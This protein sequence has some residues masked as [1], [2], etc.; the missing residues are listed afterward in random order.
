MPMTPEEADRRIALLNKMAATMHEAI[1]EGYPENVVAEVA[2]ENLCGFVVA[3]KTDLTA[4]IPSRFKEAGRR[5]M[6]L[7][8]QRALFLAEHV[9]SR[10]PRALQADS[11]PRDG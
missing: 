1:A 3:T 8:A 11:P 5:L 6:I 9:P 4:P 2:M 7:A 10:L